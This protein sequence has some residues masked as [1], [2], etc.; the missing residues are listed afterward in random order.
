ML[1][2]LSGQELIVHGV[3]LVFAS[4]ETSL[5]VTVLQPSSYFYGY[6]VIDSARVFYAYQEPGAEASAAIEV[7][8]ILDN[9]VYVFANGIGAIGESRFNYDPATRLVAF[10]WKQWIFIFSPF[11]FYDFQPR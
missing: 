2:V 11:A 1:G 10:N 7:L 4:P 3:T 6:A 8:D 9:T 5:V